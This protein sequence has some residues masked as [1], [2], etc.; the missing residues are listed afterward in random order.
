MLVSLGLASA[1]DF[2]CGAD[3]LIGHR[4]EWL[5]VSLSLGLVNFLLKQRFL[6]GLFVTFYEY[7]RSSDGRGKQYRNTTVY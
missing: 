5:L 2:G 4:A 1:K 6:T 7:R 3:T